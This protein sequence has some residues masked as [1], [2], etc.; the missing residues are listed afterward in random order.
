MIKMR[1]HNI[2]VYI[3]FI[4]AFLFLTSGCSTTKFGKSSSSDV[5]A[6][7]KQREQAPLYYDFE[8]VLL[9]KQMKLDKN[10]SFVFKTPGVSAGV[11][12]L[13]GWIDASSLITFFESNMAKDNWNMLTSFKSRRTIMLFQKETRWC[14][15]NITDRDFGGTH[16]EIWVAPALNEAS[17]GLLK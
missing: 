8:D 10:S 11:L 2:L 5:T 1:R 16:V 17:S 3:G 13:S 7:K 12:V 15:I 4:A 6:A 9:P 14:V